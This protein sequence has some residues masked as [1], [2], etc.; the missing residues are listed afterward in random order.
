[1]QLLFS[2]VGSETSG[3]YTHSVSLLAQRNYQ[4]SKKKTP[5]IE[6]I[7]FSLTGV[8]LGQPVLGQVTRDSPYD[9][10]ACAESEVFGIF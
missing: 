8:F 4:V 7:S 1:M 5:V 10:Q 2:I 9:H 3:M 6:V